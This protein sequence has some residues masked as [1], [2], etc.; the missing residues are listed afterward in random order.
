MAQ[1]NPDV[2]VAADAVREGRILEA[3][4][5]VAP[6]RADVLSRCRVLLAAVQAE[7]TRQ[8][9][10]LSHPVR[11]GAI[12]RRF[13][14]LHVNGSTWAW[15]EKSNGLVWCTAGQKPQ[16]NYPRGC[17]HDDASIAFLAS[18]CFGIAGTPAYHNFG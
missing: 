4:T 1:T 17:V 6:V 13:I 9:P 18:R 7:L 15:V 8:F 11:V 12:G 10:T 5:L 16:T 3:E 14:R 2:M